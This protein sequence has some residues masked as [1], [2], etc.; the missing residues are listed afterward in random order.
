MMQREKS[1]NSTS[2]LICG[3]LFGALSGI[4]S[5]YQLSSDGAFVWPS[6]VFGLV[7]LVGWNFVLRISFLRMLLLFFLFQVIYFLVIWLGTMFTGF[8]LMGAFLVFLAVALV[9]RLE[10]KMLL[11]MSLALFVILG[12]SFDIGYDWLDELFAG[13]Q[14]RQPHWP[15]KDARIVL[16][17]AI[18]VWQLVAMTVVSVQLH[19]ERCYRQ[20]LDLPEVM[21]MNLL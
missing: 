2:S 16:K 20:V 4:L 8:Y 13:N 10:K 12:L 19:A 21:G 15:E 5:V 14:A 11:L 18:F 9:L 6:I 17:A 7:A 1:W 3:L